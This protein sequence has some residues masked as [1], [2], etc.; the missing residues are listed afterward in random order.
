MPDPFSAYADAFRTANDRAALL[1]GALTD[2]RSNWKPAP[3]AWSVAECLEHL[4][5][6]AREYLPVLDQAVAEAPPKPERPAPLRLGLVGSL[7]V[8]AVR[9]GSRAMP[10]AP[11]MKP[12]RASPTASSLDCSRVIADMDAYTDQFLDV[13]ARAADVDAGR[14][15]VASPFLPLVKMPLAA[16]LDG[17]GQH[18]LRHVAQAERVVQQPAFAR[19]GVAADA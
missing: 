1:C 19:V 3:D 12:P 17:L 8:R 2:A 13:V 18:A 15:R 11:A 7:F 10:T 6:L 14:V 16:Y 9:P 4:N 5:V